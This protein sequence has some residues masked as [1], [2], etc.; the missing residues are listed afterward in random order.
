M[1]INT[2]EKIEDKII[3]NFKTLVNE[4][5][6]DKVTVTMIAD[7]TGIS[8]PVFYR[9][10]KDKYEL[11]D[12]MLYNEV[13]KELQSLLEHDMII[14]AIK[15]LFTHILNEA[16]LYRKLFDTVGQNNFEKVMIEQFTDFFSK[17]LK[18]FDTNLI[19]D[20]PLLSPII[21]CRYLVM[22]LT[23][24]I[25]EVLNSTI[26]FNIDQAVEAYYFLVS[27]SIFDLTRTD[28]KPK[29]FPDRK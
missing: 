4:Y 18:V 24:S 10:F 19:P 13:T 8:R 14:E 2:E 11:M 22:G 29:I 1:G 16:R 5:S 20:N 25:K 3:K 17:H 27:H 6:F 7:M 9:Y 21:I 28:F 12:Y 23:V 15:Y 26:D